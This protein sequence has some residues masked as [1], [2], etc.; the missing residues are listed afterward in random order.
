MY[1]I[2]LSKPTIKNL[3]KIEKSELK[4]IARKIDKLS[5]NPRPTNAKK[6]INQKDLFR[7]RSGDYRIIYQVKDSILLILVVN[8]GHRKDIYKTLK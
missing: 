1:K 8:I 3:K 2:K 4:K 5:N 7:I 6:L